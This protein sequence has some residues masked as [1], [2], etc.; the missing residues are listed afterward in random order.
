MGFVWSLLYKHL[1]RKQKGIILENLI[2]VNVS[3]VCQFLAE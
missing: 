1:H 3:E 2:G